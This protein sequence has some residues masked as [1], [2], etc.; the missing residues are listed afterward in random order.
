MKRQVRQGNYCLVRIL[1]YVKVYV[2]LHSFCD[3]VMRCGTAHCLRCC[4]SNK[5][6]KQ[7]SYVLLANYGV[8]LFRPFE[9]LHGLTYRQTVAFWW[10][11]RILY[12]CAFWNKYKKTLLSRFTPLQ[13]YKD[14][15]YY[16]KWF[17]VLLKSLHYLMMTPHLVLRSLFRCR[18]T[19]SIRLM[20]Y[21]FIS[22]IILKCEF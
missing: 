17:M 11:T 22:V 5:T 1:M 19:R 3:P 6:S 14:F 15:T 16:H 7:R 21:H 2:V 12:E 13:R 20:Q 18:T 10:R 8:G 4:Y 9:R